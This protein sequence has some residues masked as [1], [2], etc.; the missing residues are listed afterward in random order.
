MTTF[1]HFFARRLAIVAACYTLLFVGTASAD[2]AG[3]VAYWKLAGDCRDHS[4]H[5]HDGV[6]HGVDLASSTFNGVDAYVEVPDAPELHLGAGDFSISAEVYTESELTD[7]IGDILTKF[8]PASRRGFNLTVCA[9]NPGYN[10]QAD[11][12]N[13]FFG[14]DSGTAGVWTNCGRPGGDRTHISDALT[15]FEGNLYAGTTDGADEAEWAHVYRYAGNRL[16]EDCGRLGDGKTRGVYAM[17]VHDGALYAATTSSHGEQPPE[18]DA[19]RVYRYRGGREWEDLGA[20][21]KN[22]RVNSLASFNGKLYAAAFNV[23]Y[24]KEGEPGRC[25]EYEGG[26]TWRSC[27][28]FNGWPH[29][30]AVNDG[31]LYAAYP[32]GEVFAYDGRKWE[33]LGNPHGSLDECNQIHALGVYRGELYEGSW[34]QGKV[35]VWRHGKWVDLGQ[36]GDSTEVIA[37]TVY[38]GSFYAGSIPRAEVFR[39]DADNRWTSIRRLFDPPG[40]EPEP[41]GSGAKGVQ[42]WTRASGLAVYQGKLFASTATCYRE[43]IDPAVSSETRGEVYSFAAGA[44]VSLD[45][46]MGA[47]WRRVA[48]VRHGHTL[49]I[50]VD[51]RLV[52][53]TESDGEPLDVSNDAPLQIGF[54]P[55][56]NFAGKIREVR[57]YNR[58]L[59]K[60]EVRQLHEP[61]STAGKPKSPSRA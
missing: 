46:D 32:Q 55:Q 47:G 8:D 50:Y 7:V 23:V 4:G 16:W 20:P 10:S 37:L 5:G 28:E 38:N 56:A 57:L 49:S 51:G 54:G 60:E 22:T 24:S 52:A 6:N 35:G 29:A 33:H 12:R 59:D 17:I 2:D 18:M 30:M 19:G 1:F 41:V 11:V 26:Q 14:V 44:G 40:F 36:L 31:R 3:L 61:Q 39:L 48:A 34:P 42:N 9:S 27:G 45:R 13:L 15:V 25:Y 43:M 58:A 21:G 53:S